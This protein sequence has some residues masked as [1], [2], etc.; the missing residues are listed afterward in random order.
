MWFDKDGIFNSITRKNSVLDKKSLVETFDYIK[1]NAGNKKV[2]WISN[3]TDVLP[4]E[5]EVRDFAATETP[6]I[7]KALALITNS[8]LSKMIAEIFMLVK[9]PPYPTKL[10]TNEAEARE[11]LRKYCD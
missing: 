1:K 3:V 5:K 4:P 11:W 8:S 9:R 7:V 10:F 2:C 6:K